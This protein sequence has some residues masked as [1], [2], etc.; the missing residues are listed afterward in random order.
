MK[1]MAGTPAAHACHNRLH[2]SSI[3]RTAYLQ[4]I[5]AQQSNN[6]CS[7]QHSWQLAYQRE[8]AVLRA[9]WRW[10]AA[11]ATALRICSTLPLGDWPMLCRISTS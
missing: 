4:V 7:A 10:L 9:F 1:Q 11:A 5:Q 3:K 6:C 8:P 2:H